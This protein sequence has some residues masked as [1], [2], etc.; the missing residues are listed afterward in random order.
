MICVGK[1]AYGLVFAVSLIVLS[2]CAVHKGSTSSLTSHLEQNTPP[3][4]IADAS[5]TVPSA[6]STQ[7]VPDEPL[8][9][10]SKP[11]EEGIEEYDPWEPLNTKFFE[12]NRQ[13]DR[14]I[15]KPVAKGY[16]FVVPNVVQVGISN[17]FYNSRATP[18][19]PEQYVSGEIQ[20]SWD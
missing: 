9:P 11:G 17:V 10:F 2:G 8:D 14:W 1:R 18:R 3:V 16:N 12:F 15:L 19:F 6:A 5:Q 4:L 13:L 7:V 20:R